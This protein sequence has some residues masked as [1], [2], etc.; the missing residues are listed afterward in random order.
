MANAKYLVDVNLPKRF[1]FFNFDE[2]IHVV[3]INPRWSDSEIWNYALLH[4]L[5]ILT[6]DSDFYPKAL[7]KSPLPIIIYFKLGS[8]N[9]RQLFEYFQNNWVKLKTC[10][11]K[12]SLVI[13]YPN[14]IQVM[15]KIDV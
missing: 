1:A 5:V 6:K 2:F 15:F 9:L 13:A 11:F 7:N 8:M 4:N 14:K 10:T 3:D 12:Y